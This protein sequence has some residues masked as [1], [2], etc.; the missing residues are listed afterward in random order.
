MAE[1]TETI[2]WYSGDNATFGDRLT[3]AREAQGLSQ[4]ELSKRLGVKLKTVQAWEN[5]T[6]EPRANKLQMVAGV[7]NVSLR[8]LITGV[9]EGGVSE[10][11]SVEHLAADARAVLQE[12]QSLRTEMTDLATRLGRAEKRIRNLVKESL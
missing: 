5:D 8:W 12:M 4:A 6:S 3:A 9:G 11:A 7:L 10:P 2:D 1:E